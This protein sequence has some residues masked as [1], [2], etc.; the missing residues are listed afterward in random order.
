MLLPHSP[1][2]SVP[3]KNQNT[4]ASISY[5]NIKEIKKE[6]SNEKHTAF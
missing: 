3:E 1:E 5:N 2:F 4:L 6:N